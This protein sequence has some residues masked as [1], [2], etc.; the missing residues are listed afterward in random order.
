MMPSDGNYEQIQRKGGFKI[1]KIN[2]AFGK[3]KGLA[4]STRNREMCP[5]EVGLE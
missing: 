2:K 1:T 3:G 5:Y 4:L